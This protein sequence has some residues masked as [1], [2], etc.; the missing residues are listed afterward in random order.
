MLAVYFLAEIV[1]LITFQG[2][3]MLL[4]ILIKF[5]YINIQTR[6]PMLGPRMKTSFVIFKKAVVR[7]V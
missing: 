6:R 2:K 5:H 7:I 4:Y 3:L 1:N